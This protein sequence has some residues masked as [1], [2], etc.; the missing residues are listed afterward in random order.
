VRFDAHSKQGS[1]YTYAP[2]RRARKRPPPVFSGGGLLLT[3][4]GF[5]TVPIGATARTGGMGITY[6]CGLRIWLRNRSLLLRHGLAVGGRTRVVGRGVAL[7]ERKAGRP[8]KN[9]EHCT[10]REKTFRHG[11]TMR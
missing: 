6:G 1:G 5:L 7:R 11:N 10:S 4:V 9:T 3:L 8:E 2:A